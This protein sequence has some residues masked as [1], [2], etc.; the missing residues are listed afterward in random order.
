[1]QN[2]GHVSRTRLFFV[3]CF[4][5]A[6]SNFSYRPQ[7]RELKAK[8]RARNASRFNKFWAHKTPRLA[9]FDQ[10]WAIADFGRAE[11]PTLYLAS[12]LA[13]TWHELVTDDYHLEAGGPDCRSDPT[14]SHVLVRYRGVPLSWRTMKMA[15]YLKKLPPRAMVDWTPRTSNREADV[16]ANGITSRFDPPNV[17]DLSRCRV[18]TTAEEQ[19]PIPRRHVFDTERGGQKVKEI[20]KFEASVLQQ[21]RLQITSGGGVRL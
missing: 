15:S 20:K 9:H 11:D 3:L 14:R 7:H 10:T 6:R 12:T 21:F 2:I 18:S 19:V 5:C 16:L 1:M 17:A 13:S 4:F 8:N